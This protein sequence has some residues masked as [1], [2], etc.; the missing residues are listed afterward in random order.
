MTIAFRIASQSV[1]L[2]LGSSRP[3]REQLQLVRLAVVAERLHR[4]LPLRTLRIVQLAKVQRLALEHAP[5]NA[6]VL[7]HAPVIVDL[8]VLESL[9]RP[10]KHAGII[11]YPARLS[12]GAGLHY[13]AFRGNSRLNPAPTG[14]H[15][16]LS[17]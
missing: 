17:A 2:R 1:P 4:P 3:S 13:T 15:L 7:N 16:K 10:K 8:A 12:K 9:C 5:A 11:S 14:E 6:H